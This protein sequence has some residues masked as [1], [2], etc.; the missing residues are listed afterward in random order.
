[1]T[2]EEFNA[3]YSNATAEFRN[4]SWD[5]LRAMWRNTTSTAKALSRYLSETALINFAQHG[6][7]NLLNDHLH[8]LQTAGKNYNRPAAYVKW[9]I[10]HQP[11]KYEGGKLVKDKDS[12]MSA[13][14][15]TNQ[16]AHAQT[17]PY[18]EFAPDTELLRFGA[19]DFLSKLE[20][21]IK[22]FENKKHVPKDQLALDLIN[23]AKLKV[24]EL[25]KLIPIDALVAATPAST[26]VHKTEPEPT[27]PSAPAETVQMIV[28]QQ[29]EAA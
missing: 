17:I 2:P 4:K 14:H 3:Y 23:A 12:K 16:L 11:L 24:A 10:A 1:M 25:R 15:W 8:D 6:S 9:A 26:L 22:T 5:E 21:V 29:A 20:S 19:P 7:T 28:E 27:A 13:E 18:W